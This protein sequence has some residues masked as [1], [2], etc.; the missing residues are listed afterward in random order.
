VITTRRIKDL[1]GGVLPIAGLAL[2]VN[3]AAI[4]ITGQVPEFLRRMEAVNADELTR[5]A[6]KIASVEARA[7]AADDL[8]I[9][10]G[11]STA[12]EGIDPAL[13]EEGVHHRLR[14]LNLGSSGGSFREL[15]AYFD[16]LF[17]SELRPRLLILAVHPVWLAGRVVQAPTAPSPREVMSIAAREGVWTAEALSAARAL[18]TRWLWPLENQRRINTILRSELLL[19]RIRLGEAFALSARELF[20]SSTED[21]WK[22]RIIYTADRASDEF[23]ARQMEYWEAFGWFDANRY[24]ASGTEAI[25]LAELL[26]KARSASARTAL[27]LMPEPSDLRR[28]VPPDAERSIHQIVSKAGADVAV[29]NLREA[30]PDEFFHDHAHANKAG[31]ECLSAIIADRVSRLLQYPGSEQSRRCYAG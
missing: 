28:R 17:R 31:R 11:F 22:T 23:L 16:S 7:R 3:L 14:V 5:V 29:I 24:S 26:R 8:A 9:V 30:L 25:E 21:P 10:A 19:L 12:R 2:L 27:V 13:V 15:N 6:A 20:K 1:I 18:I 4:A